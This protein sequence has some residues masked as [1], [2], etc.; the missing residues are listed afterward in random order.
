MIE[1]CPVC[2]SIAVETIYPDMVDYFFYSSKSVNLVKCGNPECEHIYIP[3]TYSRETLLEI[4][5]DYYTHEDFKINATKKS[6][7]NIFRKMLFVYAKLKNSETRLTISERCFVLLIYVSFTLVPW[8]KG[9]F[10]S[11]TFYL[12]RKR[13]SDICEI[14][15]GDGE[16]LLNFKYI[17][18]DCSAVDFDSAAVKSARDNGLDAIVGNISHLSQFDKKFDV[19]VFRHVVEHLQSTKSIILDC[20]KYLKPDGQIVIITPNNNSFGHQLFGR[21]WRGLEA[22]RHLNIYSNKSARLV[23]EGAEVSI[24]C[25]KTTPSLNFSIYLSSISAYTKSIFKIAPTIF[26]VPL[27][28]GAAYL[29]SITNIFFKNSGEELVIICEKRTFNK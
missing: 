7:R 22:P 17:G 1:K 18:W 28:F 25:L 5:A 2:D 10:D 26:L 24:V 14:G 19:I 13:K 4:Y 21:F 15:C 6:L 16:N 8:I 29:S 12:N 11:N 20:S 9:Y 3:E 27:A 23:F